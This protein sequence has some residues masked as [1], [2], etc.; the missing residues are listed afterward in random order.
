MQRDVLELETSFRR[1]LATLQR[2]IDEARPW[3]EDHRVT[4]IERAVDDQEREGEE[5]LFYHEFLFIQDQEQG[6]ETHRRTVTLYYQEPV[7]SAVSDLVGRIQVT[8]QA[9]VFRKPSPSL[10]KQK[11]LSAI[12]VDDLSAR[13]L[14]VFLQSRFEMAVS[15][16]P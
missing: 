12:A 8:T 7:D 16:L 9:E 2:L 5:S 4:L 6:P 14:A 11:E 1:V 10:R 3:L 13:G 15:W